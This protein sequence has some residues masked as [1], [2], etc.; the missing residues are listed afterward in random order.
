[1]GLWETLGEDFDLQDRGFGRG[2]V[3]IHKTWEILG[4]DL[5]D[6]ERIWETW[7]TLGEDLQDFGIGFV[8]FWETLGEDSQ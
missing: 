1:M 6:F 7:D 8:R 5:Q 2:F 4:E 3:R